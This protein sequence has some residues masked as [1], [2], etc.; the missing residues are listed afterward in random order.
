MTRRVETALQ[1]L[2]EKLNVGEHEDLQIDHFLAEFDPLEG[3]YG[4]FLYRMLTKLWSKTSASQ[5]FKVAIYWKILARVFAWWGTG[6]RSNATDDPRKRPPIFDHVT[7]HKTLLAALKAIDDNK[8]QEWKTSEDTLNKSL[9]YL[10]G[11]PSL[12]GPT[13]L[14][15]D[16]LKMECAKTDFGQAGLLNTYLASKKRRK[17]ITTYGAN[18]NWL[19]VKVCKHTLTP[20]EGYLAATKEL[21]MVMTDAANENSIDCSGMHVGGDRG[22]NTDQCAEVVHENGGHILGTHKRSRS[23]EVVVDPPTDAPSAHVISASGC[24]SQTVAKRRKCESTRLCVVTEPPHSVTHI[25]YS[26]EALDHK[27]VVS[28]DPDVTPPEHCD[29]HFVPQAKREGPTEHA[30]QDDT[31][32]KAF[33]SAGRFSDALT[34]H[35][36]KDPR[37]FYMRIGITGRQVRPFLRAARELCSAHPDLE[38][39]VDKVDK[40]LATSQTPSPMNDGLIITSFDDTLEAVVGPL[41]NSSEGGTI[42]D[43]W[44]KLHDAAMKGAEG[45]SDCQA[46]AIDALRR[47]PLFSHLTEKEKEK[48]KFCGSRG[49]ATLATWM[50][51]MWWQLDASTFEHQLQEETARLI[52]NMVVSTPNIAK[53]IARNCLGLTDE[54]VKAMV[55]SKVKE[56]RE[57]LVDRATTQIGGNGRNDADTAVDEALKVIMPNM[58]LKPVRKDKKGAMKTGHDN[59]S[60][61]ATSLV[62]GNLNGPKVLDKH[63]VVWEVR[64]TGLRARCGAPYLKAS[65]DGV[66]AFEWRGLAPPNWVEREGAVTHAAIEYKT[67][68]K[69]DKVEEQERKAREVG[70][71]VYVD[72]RD[73]GSAAKLSEAVTSWDDRAQLLQGAA[74]LGAPDDCSYSMYVRG[75]SP[76]RI[77]RIVVVRWPSELL[78]VYRDVMKR[79]VNCAVPWMDCRES[80][81]EKSFV[82]SVERAGVRVGYGR[83][84]QH[85]YRIVVLARELQIAIRSGDMRVD[86]QVRSIKALVQV[87]WNTYK[88]GDDTFGAVMK[89]LAGTYMPKTIGP[90]AFMIMKDVATVVV[91]FWRLWCANALPDPTSFKVKGRRP[92]RVQTWR[93]RCQKKVGGVKDFALDLCSAIVENKILA[94]GE[95]VARGGGV[96]GLGREGRSRRTQSRRSLGTENTKLGRKKR[97]GMPTPGG[98]GKGRKKAKSRTGGTRSKAR[99]VRECE[100]PGCPVEFEDEGKSKR[101]Y[102]DH[103]KCFVMA[104]KMAQYREDHDAWVRRGKEGKEPKEPRKPTGTIYCLHCKKQF[105]M[106]APMKGY[107]LVTVPQYDEGGAQVGHKKFKMSCWFDAHLKGME[108]AVEQHEAKIDE[109]LVGDVTNVT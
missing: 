13:N 24:A 37:W 22:F 87:L 98:A 65:L 73:G 64:A 106:R 1:K 20:K 80:I 25:V 3:E 21:I 31:L 77:I 76:G 89:T 9:K 94:G 105:C 67:S 40:H 72:M 8:G 71:V 91:N 28:E 10:R 62:D 82:A 26:N 29:D 100:C 5:Q 66:A 4:A 34:L 47:I 42:G 108:V 46:I 103:D 83:S 18:D 90:N 41:L 54:D 68:T 78:N 92:M 11:N 97:E 107:E 74:V 7:D 59:E 14:V 16:D 39:S 50:R 44:A 57:F 99:A 84:P 93:K 56:A 63:F 79:V 102:C 69:K 43:A 61:L 17:G 70:D 104:Q 49:C 30:N 27:W 19:Q 58:L 48:D 109:A 6:V 95:G 23:D 36:G 45:D 85:L 51:K 38:E 33:K 12:G 52:I 75:A 88:T 101:K 15:I 86:M 55:P 81:D 35:Q 2:K 53:R 32:L 60:L 96:R